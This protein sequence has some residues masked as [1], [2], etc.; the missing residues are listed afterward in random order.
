MKLM[1]NRYSIHMQLKK[2]QYRNIKPKKLMIPSD[3]R[4]WTILYGS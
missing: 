4:K 2:H 1:K 3:N